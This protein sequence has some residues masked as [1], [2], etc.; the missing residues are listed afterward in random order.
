M[1]ISLSTYNPAITTAVG[2]G[3]NE[4]PPLE[5]TPEF[6]GSKK[7]AEDSSL[8]LKSSGS[9]SRDGAELSPEEKSKLKKLKQRD[10]EVR[11]HEQAHL[12]AGGSLVTSGPHYEYVQGPDGRRYVINGH[13][14]LD[15]SPEKEPKDTARKADRIVRAAM[16]PM[17]P[18]SDDYAIASNARRMKAKALQQVQHDEQTTQREQQAEKAYKIGESIKPKMFEQGNSIPQFTHSQTQGQFTAMA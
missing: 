8:P 18:S 16:A 6:S 12:R 13:V 5:S 2:A 17:N 9:K 10:Q 11:Q 3:H 15:V 4:L 7:S 1:N 14:N